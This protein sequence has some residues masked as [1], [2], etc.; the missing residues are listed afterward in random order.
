MQVLIDAAVKA[1]GNSVGARMAK[2]EKNVR[3]KS[4]PKDAGSNRIE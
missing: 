4:N 3:D 1:R 2:L